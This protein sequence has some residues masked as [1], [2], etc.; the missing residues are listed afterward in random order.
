MHIA[1]RWVGPRNVVHR[2]CQFLALEL[3][4]FGEICHIIFRAL[5]ELKPLVSFISRF[6]VRQTDRPS[7]VTIAAHAPFLQSRGQKWTHNCYSYTVLL[8]FL[9]QDKSESL[10]VVIRAIKSVFARDFHAISC[11]TI[12]SSSCNF[13]CSFINASF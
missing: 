12:D 7:N 11:T 4:C 9:R 8:L 6:V 13:K 2:Q 3:G 1:N 10:N 5:V